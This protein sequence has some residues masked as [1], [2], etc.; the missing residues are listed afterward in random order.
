MDIWNKSLAIKRQ[1]FTV[2]TF[3]FKTKC[4]IVVWVIALKQ[5]K[6][7]WSLNYN[8]KTRALVFT[9]KSSDWQI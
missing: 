7:K 5:Q 4:K 6:S 3:Q 2:K 8:N 1:I 9:L